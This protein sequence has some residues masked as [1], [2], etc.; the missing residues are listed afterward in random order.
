L[1]IVCPLKAHLCMHVQPTVVQRAFD[2]AVPK[3]AAAAMVRSMISV[4]NMEGIVTL[5]GKVRRRT[6][7]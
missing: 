3:C 2:G 6:P 7:C 1:L 5:L 4:A